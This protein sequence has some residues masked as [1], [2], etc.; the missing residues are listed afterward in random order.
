M[1]KIAFLLVVAV[2]LM[3]SGCNSNS[4]SKSGDQGERGPGNF[5]SEAMV[6]RQIEQIKETLDLSK[7]QEKQ[8]R[9]VLNN[10]MDKMMEM[11]NTMK[12]GG[13]FEGMREK[14]QQIREEQN[15]EV[16]EILSE[17]QWL[18]YDKIA[19]ERRGR[20]GQ[21]RRGGQGGAE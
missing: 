20:W 16:K 10:G 9:E 3:G 5:N 4:N 21:G 14:M 19:K 7:K 13:G 8:M 12:E 6:D 17:E 15:K 1:K 2:A 11:R 18:Q